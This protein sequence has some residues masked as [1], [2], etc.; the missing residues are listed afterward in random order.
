MLQPG[1]AFSLLAFQPSDVAANIARGQSYS[2]IL[3]HYNTKL[4]SDGFTSTE[5]HSSK[6]AALHHFPLKLKCHTHISSAFLQLGN[7]VNTSAV[8]KIWKNVNWSTRVKYELFKL[9]FAY[10]WKQSQE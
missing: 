3:W 9:C 7:P 6:F 1:Q 5:R 10:V 4:V 2:Y 8:V